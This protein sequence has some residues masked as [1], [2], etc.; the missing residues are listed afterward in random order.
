MKKLTFMAMAAV[1]AIF[2]ALPLSNAQASDTVYQVVMHL[3]ENDESRMNAVLSNASNVAKYHLKKGAKVQVE[4]VVHGPGLNMLTASSPVADRV[5]SIAS[6]IEQVTFR[7][8]ANSHK[9]M[10]K[11]A[12][13]EIVMLPEVSMVPAGI[14]HMMERQMQGWSYIRP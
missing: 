6:S 13:K 5:K 14:P 3:N 9:M 2:V 4:V 8:C 1:L 7:A 12:G 10:S 11:K